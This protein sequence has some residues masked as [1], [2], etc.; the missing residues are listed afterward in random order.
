MGMTGGHGTGG[1]G[2]DG[3]GALVRLRNPL[4]I[5]R[6]GRVRIEAQRRWNLPTAMMAIDFNRSQSPPIQS[7]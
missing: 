6:I 2:S 5:N 3:A 7:Q 1:T 4:G